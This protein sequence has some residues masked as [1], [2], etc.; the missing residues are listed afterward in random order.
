[1][2]HPP[3]AP[4][5]V[6]DAAHAGGIPPH[7]HFK[8]RSKASFLPTFLCGSADVAN[9]TS[10]M[11]FK[12]THKYIVFKMNGAIIKEHR[13]FWIRAVKHEFLLRSIL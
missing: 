9:T 1:M 6:S 11:S 7:P 5:T 2:R 4:L 12:K 8:S 10:C 13:S 3:F